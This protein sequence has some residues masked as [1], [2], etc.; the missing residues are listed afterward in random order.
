MVSADGSTEV[1]EVPHAANAPIDCLYLYP[2][3]SQDKAPNS[4]LVP[5]EDEELAA[6]LRQAARFGSV[7]D[8]YVPV[9]RQ[10]TLALLLGEVSAEADFEMPYGDVLA[11]FRHYL[12]NDSAGRGF[13]LIGHSQG[14]DLVS[15]LIR[16]EIAGV[17][18]L[19]R[20]LVSAIILGP[21]GS[22]LPDI[23]TC[24]D[25]GQVGCLLS[26]VTYD[27]ASPPPGAFGSGPALCTNPAAL[28]GGS[29]P[30]HP[31]FVVG[32][33]AIVGGTGGIPFADSA[34]APEITTAWVGY[35]DFVTGECIDDGAFGYLSV[36]IHTDPADPR[37]DHLAGDALPDIGLHH[38]DGNIALDDL[39]AAVAAQAR[40]YTG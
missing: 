33:Q 14:A 26:Y 1:V 9:Y 38:L 6:T 3:V 39:V 28:A 29:A 12:A 21:P 5:G 7:C 23:P 35:P 22:E 34:T 15:R 30:L 37:T 18:A 20:R 36:T 2:T 16:E 27:A 31:A 32:P 13:V 40:A 17:P 11:A 19:R 10:I 25:Q 24:T 4:D 8:V